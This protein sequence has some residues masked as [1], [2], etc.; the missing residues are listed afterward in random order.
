[1]VT[2]HEMRKAV[3]AL[4]EQYKQGVHT[5]GFKACPLCVMFKANWD[6]PFE[7]SCVN[8]PNYPFYDSRISALPPCSR[9]TKAFPV[10]DW[11]EGYNPDIDDCPYEEQPLL[12]KFWEQV[13]TVLPIGADVEFVLTE[14]LS[15]IIVKLANQIQIEYDQEK[16]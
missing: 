11:G 8:C 14:E 16:S 12:V 13:L 2:N 9:R 1:M 6:T 15:K 7:E 3:K 5:G 4:I 10:L